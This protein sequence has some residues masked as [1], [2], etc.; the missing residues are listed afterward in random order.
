MFERRKRGTPVTKLAVVL[1]LLAVLGVMGGCGGESDE[2]A[3]TSGAAG[4][5]AGP[6][7]GAEAPSDSPEASLPT[8]LDLGS[9]SC[10]PCKAMAPILDE[11]RETF[12]GQLVVT[13]VDVRKDPDAARE[14]DIRIIPTQIFLDE[15]GHELYRHQG[16]YS[17][18]EMLAKWA[19]LGYEFTEEEG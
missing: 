8:L 15:H 7:A 18:E 4:A 14:R 16:F 5:D 19:A 10:V 6:T 1:L 11:M 13:F 9:D 3:D 2:T 12:E 17:R